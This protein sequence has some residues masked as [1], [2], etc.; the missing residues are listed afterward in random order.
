MGYRDDFEKADK[1]GKTERLTLA[2]LPFDEGTQLVGRYLGRDLV[3]SKKK[4]FTDSYRYTFDTDDGPGSVFFSNSF[5]EKIGADL[6]E[7]SVYMF[8][9]VKKV[10]IG[11]GKTWKQIDVF[12]IPADP[13]EPMEALDT[14]SIDDPDL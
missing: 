13:S 8:H 14:T 11:G 12:K 5:D 2:R 4:G 9:Y 10:D 6:I 7:G 1:A 3:E